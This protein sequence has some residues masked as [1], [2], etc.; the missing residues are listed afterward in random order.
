M[1]AL[2]SGNISTVDNFPEKISKTPVH[3]KMRGLPPLML[4][5]KQTKNRQNTPAFSPYLV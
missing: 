1:F 4:N 5:R 2:A 3:V